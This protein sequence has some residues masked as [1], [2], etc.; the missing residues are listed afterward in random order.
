MNKA[1][2]PVNQP[3]S[4]LSLV[5]TIGYSDKQAMSFKTVLVVRKYLTTSPK[6]VVIVK[7][8]IFLQWN[9]F[10]LFK[11]QRMATKFK[12]FKSPAPPPRNILKSM[13]TNS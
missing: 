8:P 2:N 1:V 11:T 12:L 3:L 7:I 5:K 6:N 9:F 13:D 4:I 10:H